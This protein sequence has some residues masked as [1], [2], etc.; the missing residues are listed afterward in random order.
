M[1]AR[2]GR[3]AVVD[4]LLEDDRIDVSVAIQS[5]L[6]KHHKRFE[7]RERFT[8]VCIALQAMALPAWITVQILDA[9]RPWSHC[10]FTASGTW[11]ARSSTFTN[12]TGGG[13]VLELEV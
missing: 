8:E 12:K 13:L 5:S 7:Y 1:A 9:A 3:L 6:P 2:L 10:R 4:R 11:C